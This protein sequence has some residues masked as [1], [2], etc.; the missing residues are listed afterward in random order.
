MITEQDKA[1]FKQGVERAGKKFSIAMSAIA[2]ADVLFP[3]W[4]EAVHRIFIRHGWILA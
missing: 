1:E 2:Q 4:S 3:P